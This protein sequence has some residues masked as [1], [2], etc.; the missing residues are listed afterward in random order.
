MQLTWRFA[1]KTW[2]I[3][4][5]GPGCSRQVRI[6]ATAFV[7]ALRSGNMASKIDSWIALAAQPTDHLQELCL[8]NL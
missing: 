5:C 6:R 1:S 4:E 3:K 8:E 7:A 2:G